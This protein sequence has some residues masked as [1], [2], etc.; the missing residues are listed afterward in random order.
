MAMPVAFSRR[1]FLTRGGLAAGV[2]LLAPSLVYAQAQGASNIDMPQSA[3]IPVRKPVKPNAQKR[4]TQEQRDALE[5]GLKCACPC[6]L[7]VF[8]CRTTDFSCGISPA[9][10]SDVV[11]LIDGG[12]S[13]DEIV[14]AF[15]EVYGERVLMAPEKEGFNLAGYIVPG[16][17]VSIGAVTLLALLRK[18]RTAPASVTVTA[19]PVSVPG[20]SADDLARLEAAVRNPDHR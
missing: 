4:L 16:V 2:T 20:V 11:R 12:Y 7:D 13:A 1:A 9:M 10:H 8:T 19:A 18:W 6:K 14:A 3:Y 5:R 15:K 17:V